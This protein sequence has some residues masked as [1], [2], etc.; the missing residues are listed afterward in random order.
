MFFL[1]QTHKFPLSKKATFFASPTKWDSFSFQKRLL[2]AFRFNGAFVATSD[3]PG[4][5]SGGSTLEQKMVELA[6]VAKDEARS[7]GQTRGLAASLISQYG[8]R[9]L[10][11]LIKV[12]LIYGQID[13]KNWRFDTTFFHIHCRMSPHVFIFCVCLSPPSVES[14][15]LFCFFL[16]KR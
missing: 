4:E 9:Q 8:I 13:G 6:E 7:V 14:K 10:N 1:D 5:R 2:L 15:S 3:R 16:R 11:I 12:N